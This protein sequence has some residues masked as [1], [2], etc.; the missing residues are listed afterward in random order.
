MS[1]HA[2]AGLYICVCACVFVRLCEYMCVAR[3]CVCA[4]V[5]VC[6]YVCVRVGVCACGMLDTFE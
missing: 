4:S 6:A 5:P 1:V 2:C 3:A